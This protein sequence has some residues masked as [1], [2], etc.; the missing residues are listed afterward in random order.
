MSSSISMNANAKA[1]IKIT[2]L[3]ALRSASAAKPIW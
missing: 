3:T 1:A 2:K